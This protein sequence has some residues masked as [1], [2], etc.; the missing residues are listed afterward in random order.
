MVYVDYHPIVVAAT[1]EIFG[2]E[3]LARGRC[4]RSAVPR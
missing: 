1:R 2:Y 3:A 4:A